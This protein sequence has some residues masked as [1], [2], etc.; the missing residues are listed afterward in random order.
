MEEMFWAVK[1]SLTATGIVLVK[2]YPILTCSAM[3]ML[4]S[5]TNFSTN[6]KL[7]MED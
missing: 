5:G 2:R 4:L 1:K 6:R 7:L 3:W